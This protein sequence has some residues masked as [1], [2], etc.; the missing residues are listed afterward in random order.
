MDINW[1]ILTSA[2]V[3]VV[4]WFAANWLASKR[5]TKIKKREVRVEYL[6]TAYRGIESA[7]QRELTEEQMFRLE[8]AI[9]DVQLLGNETQL[10]ALAELISSGESDFTK[11]LGEIRDD[12]RSELELKKSKSKLLF[13]R[14]SC[15]KYS[16]EQVVA[17][18]STTRRG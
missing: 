4:G 2:L 11:L 5:D 15:R 17:D 12:L 3:V 6:L 14:M 1:E 8:S 10:K 18:Q 16:G 7:A 9:G 13:Y